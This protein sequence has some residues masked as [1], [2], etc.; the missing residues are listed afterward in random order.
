M[1][2]TAEG[3]ESL[4]ARARLVNAA[5]AAGVQAIDSV[6]GQVDDLE[7]LRR[8]GARS[9]GL[10]FE[11]MGCLHPRQIPVI[12]EAFTRPRRRSTRRCGSSTAFEEAEAAG[13]GR[14]E[15]RDRR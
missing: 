8:W 9:R 10:G 15:P 5:K 14:G 2:K 12:H 7:G 4:Y 13:P 3:D 6:Y 1:P 11:G